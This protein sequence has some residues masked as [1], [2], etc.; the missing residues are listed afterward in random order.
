[1]GKLIATTQMTLDSVIDQ[2]DGWFRPA[3][4]SELYGIDQLRAA[5]ALILGRKTYEGLS[6]YWPTADSDPAGFKDLVNNIP[7]YV[8]SRTLQEPLTWNSSLVRGDLAEQVAKI[9]REHS[10]NILSYGFGELAH[11]LAGLGLLDE[12][13]F[14]FHPILWGDGLRPLLSGKPAVR[15]RLISATAFSSGVVLAA[16]EPL[17]DQQ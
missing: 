3:L 11:S 1:M 4:E 13:R 10:G 5:D 9:K 8:V 2:Q 16:Y 17:R 6:A 7:K 12:V 14:W 15:F